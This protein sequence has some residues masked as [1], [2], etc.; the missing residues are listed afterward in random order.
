MKKKKKVCYVLSYRDPHYIRTRT[1]VNALSMINEVE[2]HKAI[3]KSRI[4]IIRYI[5]TIVKLILIII[6]KRPDCYII[7][8]RGHEIFWP[9]RLLAHGKKIIYDLMMSPYD[10]I[11]NERMYI[12]KGSVLDSI[13]YKYENL[14]LHNSDVII[15]DTESHRL[16]FIGLHKLPEDCVIAIPVSTDERL[17]LKNFEREECSK[18]CEKIFSVLFYG[19]F[20]PL[21][22]MHVIINAARRVSDKPIEFMLVGGGIKVEKILKKMN[23]KNVRHIPW[24]KFNELPRLIENADLC[25][26]GPFGNTGQAKRIITGKTFQILAMGKPIVVGMNAEHNGFIDKINSFVV[27]QQNSE[28]LANAILWAFENQKILK[29]IGK[30]GQMLYKQK[31]STEKVVNDLRDIIMNQIC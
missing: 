22:G 8:F 19:S 15:T 28:D 27:N 4:N 10:S 31:Y 12:T 16:Y 3:N 17:F 20:L 26:G 29:D 11:V 21:H 25:L 2:I 1:I 30:K 18:Y 13:L 5:E 9:V 24:V 14:V 7:G 6:K 23:L